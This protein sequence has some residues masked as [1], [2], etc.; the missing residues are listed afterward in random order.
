MG[1]EDSNPL[2][3]IDSQIDSQI[4]SQNK[5]IDALKGKVD[6]SKNALASAGIAQDQA[7][8]T[9]LKYSDV[10]TEAN[11]D[12][13]LFS[14][15]LK[16]L[17][18]QK[19]LALTRAES[20]A[21]ADG[22]SEEEIAQIRENISLGFDERIFSLKYSDPTESYTTAKNAFESAKESYQESRFGKIFASNN[23]F[24]NLLDLS[25]AY[26]DLGKIQ[27]QKNFL[28]LAY[29]NYSNNNI[30]FQA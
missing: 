8:E 23:Y 12:K 28:E 20:T 5:F 30:D 18:F 14:E 19:K 1:I 11:D 6:E 9:K 4:K 21:R 27:Q 16:E 29:Q 13:K 17:E 25:G 10:F 26:Y 24:S 7:E 2:S 22:K 15:R 3:Q